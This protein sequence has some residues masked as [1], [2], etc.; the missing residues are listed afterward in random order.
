MIT[1]L[2]FTVPIE[3]LREYYKTVSTEYAHLNW[4]WQSS[5][6]EVIDQWRDAAYADPANL[7]TT[8]W[9]IQSNLVDLSIPCPPWQI[10]TLETREYRNTELAFGIIKRLQYY[11]PY[12]YK[13]AISKQLPGGKVSRHSD[14]TTE[15]T[16]WIPIH[17][18]GP[19]L[20][21]DKGYSMP[22]D[23]S[24]YLLDTTYPHST[25]NNSDTDRVVLIFRLNKDKKTDL[26]NLRGEL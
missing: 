3:E 26:L 23:G 8:G 16:A 21:F 4:S 5:K 6:G 17:T 10:S 15:L 19:C 1:K 12:A 20:F 22:S 18:D 9:A 11:I 13:W 25:Q 2:N 24:A 14:D 7:L